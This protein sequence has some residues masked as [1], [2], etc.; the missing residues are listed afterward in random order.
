MDAYKPFNKQESQ[1]LARL[2]ARFSDLHYLEQAFAPC[3][4]TAT[5]LAFVQKLTR[6]I[7]ALDPSVRRWGR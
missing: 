2:R 6:L 7:R 5:F 1:L 4:F 3:F